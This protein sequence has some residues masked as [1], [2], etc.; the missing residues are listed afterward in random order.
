MLGLTCMCD[1][2]A[3]PGVKPLITHCPIRSRRKGGGWKIFLL[4][5]AVIHQHGSLG[6]PSAQLSFCCSHMGCFQGSGDLCPQLGS[7]CEVADG[8]TPTHHFLLCSSRNPVLLPP[9]SSEPHSPARDVRQTPGQLVYLCGPGL[10]HGK[11]LCPDKRGVCH[12][13]GVPSCD[14]PVKFDRGVRHLSTECP[15]L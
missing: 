3:E 6:L 12:H 9:G 5:V 13:P 7:F 15:P 1:R 10:I 4:T 14:S 2:R 11:D 8:P